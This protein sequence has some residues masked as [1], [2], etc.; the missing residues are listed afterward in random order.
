MKPKSNTVNT[1]SITDARRFLPIDVQ[2]LQISAKEYKFVAEYCT[3]G[4]KAPEAAQAAGYKGDRK[5]LQ[6]TAWAIL[7]RPAVVE[8]VK[9][10][11]D[12]VIQPY[13]ARLEFEI[14]DRYYRRATYQVD[15]FFDSDGYAKDLSEIPEE[16]LQ[17]IDGV[18]RRFF[19]KNADVEVITY[20]LPNRD[21]ALQMLYK[22]ATG[23]DPNNDKNNLLPQ[24]ARARLQQIFNGGLAPS[25][26]PLKTTTRLTL[27]QVTQPMKGEAGRPRKYCKLVKGQPCVRCN[28]C[29]HTDVI[30]VI[31][32][33]KKK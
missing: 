5:T 30:D 24:E 9:R 4:F 1:L 29:K 21:T 10:F 7:K 14:L 3:N 22:L 23:N 12:S 13:K 2:D 15:T 6:S 20:L 19:G 18:E 16:W 11:I 25:N 26:S 8:C 27:E 17:V 31:P 33:G 32:K 28:R